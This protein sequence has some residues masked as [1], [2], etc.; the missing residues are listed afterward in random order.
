M[1]L[2]FFSSWRSITVLIV[3]LMLLLI[4]RAIAKMTNLLQCEMTY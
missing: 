3:I 1:D 2:F 4:N